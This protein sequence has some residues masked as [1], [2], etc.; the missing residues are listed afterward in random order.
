MYFDFKLADMPDIRSDCKYN[1]MIICNSM[2]VFQLS[3]NI[4][5]KLQSHFDPLYSV[6]HVPLYIMHAVYLYLSLKPEFK[7]FDLNFILI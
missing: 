2:Q 7:N 6:Y 1:Q 5:S 4:S 3:I